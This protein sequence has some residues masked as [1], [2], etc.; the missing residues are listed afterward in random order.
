[1]CAIEDLHV[2]ICELNPD[3][4][5][6][7]VRASTAARATCHT[8]PGAEGRQKQRLTSQLQ[9][10]QKNKVGGSQ[11]SGGGALKLGRDG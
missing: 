4:V 6:N 5:G 9:K 2:N 11:P 7:S 10:E 1:M 8:V 3:R